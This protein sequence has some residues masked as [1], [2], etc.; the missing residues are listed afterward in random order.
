MAI[1]N[2]FHGQFFF[3]FAALTKRYAWTA[4]RTHWRK[5][6]AKMTKASLHQLLCS[7]ILWR[8]SVKSH[9]TLIYRTG[10]I[11]RRGISSSSQ[12]IDFTTS[13]QWFWGKTSEAY[14]FASLNF[15]YKQNF[16]FTDSSKSLWRAKQL[17]TVTAQ[18][19]ASISS[20]SRCIPENEVISS[21]FIEV[22]LEK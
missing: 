22:F 9:D 11:K 4:S 10:S 8:L 3:W 7:S 16:P 6:Y 21:C 14:L 2:R 15:I 1:I 20:S 13:N 12:T 17:K 5:L 19:A 18:L